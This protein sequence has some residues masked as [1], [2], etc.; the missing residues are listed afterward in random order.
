MS[1]TLRE[2][3]AKYLAANGWDESGYEV[4][5]VKIQAGPIP[6]WIPNTEGRKKAV[7]LHDLH[8][9]LTG[10][11]TTWTGE[12]EIG[13][14]ELAGGCGWHFAAWYLNSWAFLIGLFIAPRRTLR[15]LRRGFREKNLYRETL[16]DALLDSKVEDVRARL[17]IPDQ[18]RNDG[19]TS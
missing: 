6:I 1:E 18:A 13:G 17:G 11:Q 14:W 3:R 5:W 2:G 7:R 16:T 9:V 4:R 15:A 19:P 10:F 8:H 12:A